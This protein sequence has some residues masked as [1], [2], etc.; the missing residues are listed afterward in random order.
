MVF[1]TVLA[2]V[3]FGIPLGL[4]SARLYRGRE[5]TRLQREATRA[6]AAL[7]T[8]GLQSKDPIELPR[9]SSRVQLALYDVSGR[10]VAGR[11]PSAGG[12]VVTT[13]LKGMV[14]D[15]HNGT[16][17]AVAIPILDEEQTVGAARAAIAWDDVADAT[18]NSWMLMAAFGLGAI[19]FAGAIARWQSSRL[20]APVHAVADLAI[21]LGNGDF[22]A[23]LAPS[24]IAELDRAADALNRTAERLG[25]LLARERAFTADV[26]HQ[27][28]T[29][30]TSLRLGLE[31]ALM[32]PGDDTISSVEL[33]LTEVDRLQT[34]VATLLAVARDVPLAGGATCDVAAICNELAD[35]RRGLLATAGRPL[36]AELDADLPPARCPGDVLRE[37]LTVLMDNARMHG[38]GAVTMSARRAGSG[39]VIDVTDE[40][41]GVSG[42]VGHLF[43][44]RSPQAAGHGIGLA[45]AR[46]LAEAHGARLEVTAA[47][48][49]P[50]FTVAL[51]GATPP[52]PD[53]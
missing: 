36:R 43:Q 48:S 16:W 3:L 10:R 25:D 28:N 45:L 46:S 12:P 31:S 11:G 23:R 7:P 17:L 22:T 52:A 41:K 15:G 49:R 4:A 38:A 6:A 44:R 53:L 42:D 32:M 18:H 34:T 26:S 51:P 30:L 13:A 8:G 47:G 9:T 14:S 50:V 27:L 2:V 5:V 20:V 1:V 33:A 37:I 24:G 40:G 19:A 29:P 39:V 21:R 35:R